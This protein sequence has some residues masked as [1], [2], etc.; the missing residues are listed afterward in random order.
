MQNNNQNY[1]IT[2]LGQT[3][4]YDLEDNLLQQLEDAANNNDMVEY[5]RLVSQNINVFNG[6][7]R[8][9]WRETF[10]EGSSAEILFWINTPL[11]RLSVHDLYVIPHEYDNLFQIG[12]SKPNLD[13]EGSECVL[14]VL[15]E[16]LEEEDNAI[17]KSIM[18]NRMALIRN[19]AAR[20]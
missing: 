19:L 11:R 1:P 7:V 14:E 4:G 20:K 10:C 12:L 17:T 3:A 18:R 9:F 16:Y 2:G 6:I 5:A 8:D 15:E 13:M